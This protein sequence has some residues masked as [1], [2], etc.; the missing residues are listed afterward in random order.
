MK[1]EFKCEI[2]I[3]YKALE[4]EP[5]PDKIFETKKPEFIIPPNKDEDPFSLVKDLTKKYTRK[6]VCIFLP[7]TRFDKH[8]TRHGRGG[9][10]YDRFLSRAPKEWIR[11]GVANETQFTS[12]K[13]ERKEWDEPVDYVIIVGENDTEIIKTNSRT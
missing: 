9:G 7:G 11:I 8:G 13:L 3:S 12:K 2:I 6:S 1:G 5:K 4:D 10:W